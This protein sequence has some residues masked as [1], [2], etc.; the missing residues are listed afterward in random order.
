MQIIEL[1]LYF[2]NVVI[3]DIILITF[4]YFIV[5]FFQA[6]AGNWMISRRENQRKILI[7]YSSQFNWMVVYARKEI[8]LVPAKSMTFAYGFWG[9]YL[10]V[11]GT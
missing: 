8:N 2:P 4:F 5:F 9:Q 7:E 3:P 11:K 6:G 10:F 1:W